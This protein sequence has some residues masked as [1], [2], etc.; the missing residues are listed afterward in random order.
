MLTIATESPLHPDLGLLMQRHRQAMFEASPPESV[1]MLEASALCTEG[2]RFY[3]MR[4]GGRPVG[5]GAFKPLEARHAE[6]KSMHVLIEERG[7]GLARLLLD[8]LL[9][10][11]KEAGFTHLSLE[12]GPKPC[13]ASAR[14]LYL[15]AG[16]TECP[17]FPPYVED[18]YSTFM[19]RAL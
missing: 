6:I 3:V 8:H 1:H 11:A 14:S 12:T 4:D 9:L 5:M 15:K 18:P 10:H 13:F 2:I 7:R 19:A 16:F 17:P